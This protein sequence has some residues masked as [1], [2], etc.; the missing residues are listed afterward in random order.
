MLAHPLGLTID[1]LS[2]E[3]RTRVN[4][5]GICLTKLRVA[6]MN[7]HFP[8]SHL[9]APWVADYTPLS[10]TYGPGVTFDGRRLHGD[11]SQSAEMLLGD[12]GAVRD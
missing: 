9:L 12:G 6:R 2:T 3:S 11:G 8:S 10:N 4:G 1:F 7:H 5:S